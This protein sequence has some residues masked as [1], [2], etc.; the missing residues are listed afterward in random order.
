ME[1]VIFTAV[2]VYITR[3]S[4]TTI[5]YEVDGNPRVGPFSVDLRKS[6]SY[7]Y[8]R[9]VDIDDEYSLKTGGA[10]HAPLKEL[11]PEAVLYLSATYLANNPDITF[12]L[13]KLDAYKDR[14]YEFTSVQYTD[15]ASNGDLRGQRYYGFHGVWFDGPPEN[16]YLA[17]WD[18]GT[19]LVS[20][21]VPKVRFTNITRPD[22]VHP[23]D[24]ILQPP[25]VKGVPGPVFL[26]CSVA[27]TTPSLAIPKI[28]A[29]AGGEPI[30]N[31]RIP[32]QP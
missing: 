29:N 28:P 13:Y 12:P 21:Q 4:G 27:E 25:I 6:P 2:G 22:R 17:V 19:S 1:R 3:K 10:T 30:D 8:Y 31:C 15:D 32:S 9:D 5:T 26:S 24:R 14:R 18:A 16:A 23:T 11:R 20:A 7:V